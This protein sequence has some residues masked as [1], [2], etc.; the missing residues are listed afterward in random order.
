MRFIQGRV[1]YPGENEGGGG[2]SASLG[3]EGQVAR[4]VLCSLGEVGRRVDAD[5]VLAVDDLAVQRGGLDV[6]RVRYPQKVAELFQQER[7][8]LAGWVRI[9][10]P[11][12]EFEQL[13]WSPSALARLIWCATVSC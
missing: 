4:V 6:L 10:N 8:D 12:E 5:V 13:M 2:A 3:P 7:H 9:Q 11:A 1:R